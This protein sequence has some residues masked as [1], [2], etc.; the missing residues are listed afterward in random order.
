MNVHRRSTPTRR[1][2]RW[3]FAVA[4][5]VGLLSAC[6]SPGGDVVVSGDDTEPAPTTEV[7][8]AEQPTAPAEP[9]V[10]PTAGADPEATKEPTAAPTGNA[11][12]CDDV[13][14]F[15]AAD[16]VFPGCA[17]DY[18]VS[19]EL[20][21]N[22]A[23]WH[24]FEAVAGQWVEIDYALT[25]CNVEDEISFADLLI[26]NDLDPTTVLAL[27]SAA[28]VRDCSSSG[29]GQP[30]D[31]EGDW[32]RV[33]GLGDHDFG[34]VEDD[35]RTSLEAVFGAAVDSFDARECGA[36]PMTIVSYHD[37]TVQFQDGE[38]IGWFY[39]SSEPALTT[40]SGVAPGIDET[41]LRDVYD[42]VEIDET[43]L[44]TEF[45]FEVPAGYIGG[46][47]EAGTV[48][49]LYAGTNCFFR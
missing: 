46:F 32:L 39:T 17:G 21:A 27:C 30:D 25:C 41:E 10:R 24:L 2:T 33:N 37:F 4:A 22:N 31:F 38:F 35:V 1:R 28:N 42:G 48:T 8:S 47:L 12:G 15:H 23:G 16:S 43:T 7:T 20:F 44:G 13:P 45:F 6:S 18:A 49:S 11:A 14:V 19:P 9:T 36:G 29:D 26:R 34:A 3:P 5:L 40:P